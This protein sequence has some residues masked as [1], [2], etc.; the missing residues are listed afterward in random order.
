M[1]APGFEEWW[2]AKA[3]TGRDFDRN[4][5]S[6]KGYARAA[7]DA[8]FGAGARDMRGRA[9]G[10]CSALCREGCEDRID[11]LRVTEPLSA[12]STGGKPE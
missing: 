10:Q 7:W 1:S 9:S 2:A 5:D 11:A 6:H 3:D 4:F 12:L 8:A